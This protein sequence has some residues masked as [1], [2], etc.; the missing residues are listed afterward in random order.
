MLMA[1]PS[2]AA[3]AMVALRRS[4]SRSETRYTDSAVHSTLN[5]PVSQGMLILPRKK[6]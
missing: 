5:M 3:K 4:F 2:I 1:V 6:R